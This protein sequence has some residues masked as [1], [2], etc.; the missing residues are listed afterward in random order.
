[1]SK[2]NLKAFEERMDAVLEVYGLTT[3]KLK[4]AIVER[5]S[6]G[7]ASQADSPAEVFEWLA[8]QC[9]VDFLVLASDISG[10]I[11]HLDSLLVAVT[12][13]N[14]GIFIKDGEI[15]VASDGIGEEDE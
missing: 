1:M 6:L 2:V 3:E 7:A 9:G 11:A 10:T 15:M 4:E 13:P 14:I 12:D 8:G 5:L